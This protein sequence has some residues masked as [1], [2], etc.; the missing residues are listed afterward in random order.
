MPEAVDELPKESYE[1][2]N[3]MEYVINFILPHLVCLLKG[4]HPG[5]GG[6]QQPLPVRLRQ[7]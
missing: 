6:A 4:L 2:L 1:L 7:V 5:G 3:N